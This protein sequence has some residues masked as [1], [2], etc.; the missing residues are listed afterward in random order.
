[1]SKNISKWQDREI[2]GYEYVPTLTRSTY[3]A[4]V[5]QDEYP[6]EPVHEYGDPVIRVEARYWDGV[7]AAYTG[8][9]SHSVKDDGL[10]FDATDV[11]ERFAGTLGTSSASDVCEL[12]DRYLRIFHG[13]SARLISSR[14]H[15]GG[16]DYIVYDTRAMRE[17]RGCTGEY[18]DRSDPSGEEWQAYIDGEVFYIEIERREVD[19]RAATSEE[20]AA[21]RD[22]ELEEDEDFLIVESPH[23]LIIGDGVTWTYVDSTHGYYG[24][25]DYTYEAAEELLDTY[26]T[27]ED[28]NE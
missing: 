23:G 10:S 16:P 15:Y 28:S 13:G 2:G 25:N 26:E 6:L 8:Y 11:I 12:F 7:T 14:L 22:G 5:R 20:V 18:L 1:M 4:T 27:E 19:W 21:Y 24:L 3:R 17:A 9:G